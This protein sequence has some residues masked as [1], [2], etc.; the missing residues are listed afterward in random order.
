MTA[1]AIALFA[2]PAAQAQLGTEVADPP[3][4]LP[5]AEPSPD[6][7]GGTGRE[8]DEQVL[9]L[10]IQ[11][12]PGKIFNP[13]TAAYD[14]VNLRSYT[15]PGVQPSSR[16]I[17]PA[18]HTRPGQT[19]RVK[20][21]N[22]LPADPTCDGHSE[23]NKPHCF[24]GTNLHSHGLWVNPAGN[25]DNVLL[26][27]NP[28]V[29]FEYEYGIPADHPAG[30]FWYHTHRHGSTA[31]QVSSGMAGALIVHGSRLPTARKNGDLDTLLA[32]MKDRT[33][34]L[35]Q[36]QYGC[37]DANKN[38]KVKKNDKGVVVAWVCDK[39]D[40]GVIETYSDAN[41]NGFGSRGWGQSARY[42]SINGLILPDFRTKQG[43]VERWR[44]IHGGVH[45]TIALRFLKAKSDTPL[46]AGRSLSPERMEALIAQ[47]CTGEPLPYHLVAADGLTLGSAQMTQ[48]A[49][50]Q[51]GYR[52]DALVVFPEAGSYCVIDSAT[53][54]AESVGGTP[55][56]SRLLGMVRVAAGTPVPD[57]HAYLTDQLV[58]AAG[59]MKLPDEIAKAVTAD[60]RGGLRLSRFVPHADVADSEIKGT[61]LLSFDISKTVPDGPF[62]FKVGGKSGDEPAYAP[63][64]YAPDRLDRK[65]TLGTAQQWE[66]T[67]L[68][69]GHPF[70]IHVNPFQ[71]VAILDPN[72]RDVSGP[73]VLPDADPQY[74]GFRDMWKDTVWVEKG[75][76]LKM[77][78]RYQRYI[79]EF[80]LHCHILDHE[81]QGMMQNVAI[82]LPGGTPASVNAPDEGHGS[83]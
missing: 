43:Q 18:I 9:D 57:L 65:L 66:M 48:L 44:M 75:Y 32:G 50:F 54:A 19:V 58:A 1:L 60:L 24:N 74:R 15:R 81:D 62:E 28:G 49:T 76:T 17:S 46:K 63:R 14:D 11:Y 53:K 20:L 34:V 4:L 71:V 2:A 31:L 33:M 67:S 77:R 22:R 83:H 40:T 7:V 35:Q 3:P 45:D 39:G 82:V 56:G 37:L 69:A 72:G 73:E 21:H 23:P 8:G 78:T 6:L 16:Y 42:T 36:I 51:P 64:P 29:S 30:T 12:V 13:A 10:N 70:H 68:L 41:G 26:S 47:S 38:I 59:R 52:F 79:G 55:S 27:I 5:V 25:G 80:V 61:E